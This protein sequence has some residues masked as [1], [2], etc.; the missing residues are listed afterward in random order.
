[1]ARQFSP[2][3]LQRD[4]SALVVIDMQERL[5]PVIA[6]GEAVTRAAGVLIEA[7]RQLEVPVVVTEQYPKGLGPTVD[8]IAGRLPNDATVIEKMTFSAARNH[9][10]AFRLDGLMVAGRDHIVICGVESHV[11]V[12]Q[13]AADLDAR[14]YIVHIVADACGSRAPASKDAALARFR[15]MGVSCVTTEM[16]LFEWLEVAG[17]PEFKAVSRLV[18]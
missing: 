5:M 12:M 7:S 11:C 17:T 16:A 18:K 8:A 14:G 3:L 15:A 9:D 2:A 4:R 6:E 1:M 13:T 10:F